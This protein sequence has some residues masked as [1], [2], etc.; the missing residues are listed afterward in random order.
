MLRWMRY[1]RIVSRQFTAKV[2]A[3]RLVLKQ[4]F[5]MVSFQSEITEVPAGCT[6]CL[7][8]CHWEISLHPDALS[9]DY[10]YIV[11]VPFS[12]CI[13]RICFINIIF[14]YFSCFTD[15]V[16]LRAA[17]TVVEPP[18]RWRTVQWCTLSVTCHPQ[19]PLPAAV[20]R[21]STSLTQRWS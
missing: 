19:R 21:S 1:L 18:G 6:W 2:F 14:T 10:P 11:T 8:I 4:K 3:H 13:M 5:V 12:G 9:L 16:R 15:T 17:V 7:W 20:R